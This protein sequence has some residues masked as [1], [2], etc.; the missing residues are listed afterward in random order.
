MVGEAGQV[1]GVARGESREARGELGWRWADLGL[2]ARFFAS[3]VSAAAAS[4][5]VAGDAFPLHTHHTAAQRQGARR[6]S[7]AFA[8]SPRLLNLL[9]RL[10]TRRMRAAGL[11]MQ[12]HP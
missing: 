1:V 10:P 12:H 8:A 2:V 11:P 5:R 9:N 3:F 4:H 7:L 6:R